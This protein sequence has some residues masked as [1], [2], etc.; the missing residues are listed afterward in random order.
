[1]KTRPL[2][3]LELTALGI[4]YK[5][6]KVIAHDVVQHFANSQSLS[7]R[8]GAGSIYP[9]LKRLAK[10]GYL[11]STRR[12]YEIEPIGIEALRD[13]LT[14]PFSRE[15]ISANLDLLRSRVYFLKILDESER[16]AFVGAA[17]ERLEQLREECL[18]V[19]EANEASGDAFSACAM[20]GA[21]RETEARI[22]WLRE[23]EERIAQKETPPDSGLPG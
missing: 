3:P 8:S 20:L 18:A 5:Q 1:M 21:V 2:T 16:K 6:T 9:L 17:I 7:Y 4:I 13:W 23:I 22:S 10:R 19:L 14:P 11:R 15:D 12:A